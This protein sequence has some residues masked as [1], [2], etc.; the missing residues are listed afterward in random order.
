MFDRTDRLLSK[1]QRALRAQEFD[2]AVRHMMSAVETD[3]EYPHL[4]MYL[5]IAQSEAGNVV[6]A[7]VTL[8][9]ATA[10]DP[11]NFVFP[12]ELGIL[13]LDI[14]DI[15]GAETLFRRAQTLSPE[16]GLVA[17]YL[18]L[19]RLDRGEAAAL[20]ELQATLQDLP[21]SFRA[22]VLTRIEHR[23]FALHG[24]GAC[25][26]AIRR[27]PRHPRARPWLARL[28]ERRHDRQ[29]RKAELIMLRSDFED[30]L[31][32]LS[33]RPWLSASERGA[34]I[35]IH[36]RRGAAMVLECA[37][38]WL[39]ANQPD[40]DR[41]DQR[42]D[43]LFRLGSHQYDL[44]DYDLAYSTLSKCRSTFSEPTPEHGKTL[45]ATV[46]L[47]MGDLRTR[48]AAYADAQRLC[49]EARTLHPS[50]ELDWV[51]AIAHLGAND[52]RGCRQHIE[53]FLEARIFRADAHVSGFIE[54]VK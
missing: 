33:D 53:A 1:G 24:A 27:S 7:N 45:L 29:L 31:S 50:P 26:Q 10:L 17:G 40:G 46:L 37:L 44:G 30:T 54:S 52:L 48:G 36:A 41:E 49:A 8:R 11:R 43:L 35:A 22:R 3:P 16:N 38:D 20:R 14:G 13:R 5:G 21:H 23:R 9:R 4:Y 32:Y 34:R 51:D 15:Q 2:V 42:R 39:G 28:T 19:C 12:M 18:D 47:W 25:L 6:E